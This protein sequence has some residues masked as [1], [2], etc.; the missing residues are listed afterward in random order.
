M[1]LVRL[2][3]GNIQASC[4][5]GEKPEARC[6]VAA[7]GTAEDNDDS[8]AAAAAV[9]EMGDML[10]EDV[11]WDVDGDVGEDVDGVRGHSW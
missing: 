9:V 7:W 10:E 8:A 1:Y 11:D 3:L 5:H 4:A 6:V 2:T